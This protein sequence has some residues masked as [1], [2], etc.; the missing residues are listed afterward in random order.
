MKRKQILEEELDRFSLDQRRVLYNNTSRIEPTKG[1][2][3]GC[4]FC[5]ANAPRGVRTQIPFQTLER[6]AKEMGD[7]RKRK[8]RL[9]LYGASEPLDYE[10]RGKNYFDVLKLFTDQD[11]E[12]WTTTA[13]PKRKEELAIAN[14]DKIDRISISHMNRKRLMP[15]FDRLGIGVYVDLA[16]RRGI[17]VDWNGS[18][19]ISR[20]RV[21]ES[22]EETLKKLNEQNPSLPLKARFY[23]LRRDGNKPRYSLETNDE[24]FLF[25][26]SLE[27]KGGTKIDIEDRD[28]QGFIK[29]GRAFNLEKLESAIVWGFDSSNYIKITPNGFFNRFDVKATE[30]NPEGCEIEKI[31]PEDFRV[32]MLMSEPGTFSWP[33][34][35]YYDSPKAEEL[36]AEELKKRLFGVRKNG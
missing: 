3:I 2:S 33:R 13:I 9:F 19:N 15:F 10:F 24:L 28:Y 14:L 7:L 16:N 20:L 35:A 26:D 12:V 29:V 36:R 22:I 27:R 23:D 6:I 21:E 18:S 5:G 8:D 32:L 1:C 4:D 34:E 30:E 11:F 17:G 31:T 25:C